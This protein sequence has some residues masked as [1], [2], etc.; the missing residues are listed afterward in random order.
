[1][2]KV[3]NR[4]EI[5]GLRAIAVVPVVLFH[6]AMGFEGGYVGVDVFFVISGYLITSLILA[7]LKAQTFR[8]ADFWERRVRRIMPALVVMVVACLAAGWLILLPTDFDELGRS[9]V[10][11]SLLSSNLYFWKQTGYFNADTVQP[12]L[13]TW[14]LAVEEQF[15]L[16][17]PFFLLALKRVDDRWRIRAIGLVGIISFGLN[18]YL[19]YAHPMAAFYLLPARAWELLLGSLLAALPVPEKPVKWV[20]ESLSVAGL[21]GIIAAA[22]FYTKETR[23]PGVAALL[24]CLGAAAI[25]WSNSPTRTS[26]GNALS[27]G[28]IVLVGKVSYSFYLWHWPILVFASYWMTD[29]L[30]VAGRIAAVTGSFVLSLLSW[31][32]VE[33]PFRR[34]AANSNRSKVF[35]FAVGSLACLM[36]TGFVVHREKGF[37]EKWSPECLRYLAGRDDRE[38]R[39][40]V[41]LSAAQRGNLP[42]LGVQGSDRPI[43]LLVWGDSHARTV[44][45]VL[46]SVCADF[47]VHGVAATHAATAPLLGFKNTKPFSL[48]AD[49]I[50]YNQAIVDF[51]RT[52]QVRNVL[53]VA[54]WSAY[55]PSS[56]SEYGEFQ[57]ALKKTI[58][59]LHTT[60]ARIFVMK[61]VPGQRFDVPRALANAVARSR[62]PKALGLPASEHL[63]STKY[64][65]NL[66]DKFSGTLVTVLDPLPLLTDETGLCRAERDGRAL[67]SDRH[68][69]ST[70]GAMQLR[71]LFETIFRR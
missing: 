5:D 10:A 50:P 31:R 47:K 2:S 43:E 59:E 7:D 49:S 38:D 57:E 46:D 27:R 68:H 24:P 58:D 45:D 3:K 28:P 13:H 8:I 39:R 21:A 67:Y 6:A 16:L 60:G 17:F 66:L 48:G 64:E 11:Q 70:Y 9:V 34:R 22:I 14:S 69:L 44:L 61:D 23:F 41:D 55:L 19:T 15:Y 62:D 25:I 63:T 26:V 29:T 56:E 51:V 52:R 20:N 71:P 35:A 33:T 40:D 37:I 12:L 36:L 53:V 65:N 18:L 4:P 1:M 30:P 42:E 32:L 54:R